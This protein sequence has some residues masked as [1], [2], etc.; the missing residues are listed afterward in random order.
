MSNPIY[1]MIH[2][3]YIRDV[4]LHQEERSCHHAHK[5]WGTYIAKLDTTV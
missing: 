5:T 4:D 3:W 1:L 2:K